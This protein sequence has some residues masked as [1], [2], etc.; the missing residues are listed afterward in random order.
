MEICIQN[1]NQNWYTKSKSKPTFFQS[2]SSPEEYHINS[3]GII[4]LISGAEFAD[5]PNIIVSNNCK[6]KNKIL[7]HG[8]S[9]LCFSGA[10]E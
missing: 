2:V 3:L 8:F 5:N 9:F 7:F 10:Y 4:E 1:R 6:N